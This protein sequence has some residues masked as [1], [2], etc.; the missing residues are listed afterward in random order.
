MNNLSAKQP[1]NGELYKYVPAE[2]ALKCLPEVGDGSLRATQP[3]ALNDPFECAVTGSFHERNEQEGNEN[4]AQILTSL[5]P[6]TPVTADDVAQGREKDRILYLRDLLSRQ[7][8]QRFGIVSFSRD[9]FHPL[10]WSHYTTDGSGFVIGYDSTELSQL[11]SAGRLVKVRYETTLPILP[12]YPEL[13]EA[14]LR[15]LLSL[16]GTHWEYEQEWRL[17]VELAHTIG[18]GRND[19]HDLPINLL[20]I[21]NSAVSCVYHTERIPCQAVAEIRSRLANP[22]NRYSAPPPHKLSMSPKNYRYEL[23]TS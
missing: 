5:H 15:V 23:N 1:L 18:T 16:K 17:I 7:L 10:L 13:H 6:A 22:N 2:L 3:A 8:S 20:R 19:R 14:N 12:D 11:V 4:F 9:P 21:S